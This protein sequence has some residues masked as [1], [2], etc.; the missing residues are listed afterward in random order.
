MIALYSPSSGGRARPSIGLVQMQRFMYQQCF[1]W[2]D[3]GVEYALYNT[4]DYRRFVGIDLRC[5]A[6]PDTSTLLNFSYLLEA[7]QQAESIFKCDQRL[8]RL[9]GRVFLERH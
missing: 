2:S 3:E 4:M 9:E 7:H 5:E 8:F 1:G 6:A